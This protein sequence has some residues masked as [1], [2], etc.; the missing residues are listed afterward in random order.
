[1]STT[2]TISTP[3]PASTTKDSLIATL[4][5]HDLYIKATIPLLI[6]YNKTSATDVPVLNEPT[7]YSITDK[8][9]IGQVTYTLTL[10]NRTEGIDARVDAKPPVGSLI[11]KS[12]WVV[13]DEEVKEEVEIEANIVMKRMVRGTVE[14]S[15]PE[16][17][18]QLIYDATAKG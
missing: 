14:K 5:N 10:T 9:P 4:H 16:Q 3:L 13:T 1:M 2:T 6:T 7:T 12:H 15:H 17:H 11:I 18:L 8:K